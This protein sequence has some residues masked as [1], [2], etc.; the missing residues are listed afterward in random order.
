MY[1]YRYELTFYK[2]SSPDVTQ[3]DIE[4]KHLK[5]DKQHQLYKLNM[6]VTVAFLWYYRI[7]I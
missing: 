5:I 1:P 2:Y 6:W 7:L 3:R 4:K